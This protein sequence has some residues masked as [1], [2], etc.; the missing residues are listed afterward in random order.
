MSFTKN[1][2][3]EA[4]VNLELKIQVTWINMHYYSLT[5]RDTD[6]FD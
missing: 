3:F 2:G 5:F 1:E 6:S 4:V